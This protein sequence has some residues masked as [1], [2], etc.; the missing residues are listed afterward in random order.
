MDSVQQKV[1][2]EEERSVGQEVINMEQES[3]HPVLDECPN[4]IASQETRSG[5]SDGRTSDADAQPKT[6][7]TRGV[8]LAVRQRGIGSTPKDRLGSR[9]QAR[10]LAGST[11]LHRGAHEQRTRDRDPHDRHDVPHSTREHL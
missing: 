8:S 10:H 2:H 9:K 6:D 3:V 4:S 1:Q 7:S 11:E 5:L